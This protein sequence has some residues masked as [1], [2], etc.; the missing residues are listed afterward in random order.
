MERIKK[1][2]TKER[3][4]SYPNISEEKKKKEH[5]YGHGR[6]EKLPKHEK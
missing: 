1:S 5:Q 4:E 2:C 6:Y 3:R